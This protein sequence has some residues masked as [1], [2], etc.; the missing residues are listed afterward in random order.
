MYWHANV[1]YI[2]IIIIMIIIVII[3]VITII[4]IIVIIIIINII[5][6]MS[7]CRGVRQ[8]IA[9]RTGRHVD[10]RERRRLLPALAL[11]RL[12]DPCRRYEN[13]FSVHFIDALR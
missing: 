9:R 10:L 13:G 12:L 4:I 5:I 2:V 3:I 1:V 8:A 6:I 7:S 11:G